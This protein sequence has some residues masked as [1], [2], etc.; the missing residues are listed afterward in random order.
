MIDSNEDNNNRNIN[1]P[2]IVIM[3]FISIFLIINK[4]KK[5]SINSPLIRRHH[6]SLN[7]AI[8]T[9][10]E[11]KNINPEILNLRNPEI[12]IVVPLGLEPRISTL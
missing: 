2:I 4:F 6:V 12:N 7:V 8:N 11:K 3:Y 9:D 10:H 5:E 1:I